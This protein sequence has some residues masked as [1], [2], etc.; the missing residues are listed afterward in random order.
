MPKD[1]VF[2][3]IIAA[4]AAAYCW[5]REPPPPDMEERLIAIGVAWLLV[6]GWRLIAKMPSYGGIGRFAT[7]SSA[8]GTRAALAIICWVV[9]LIF[10]GALALGDAKL[11]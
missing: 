6:A 10:V 7:Q 1:S 8:A 9:F 3:A 5:Q 2:A 4:A 11:N